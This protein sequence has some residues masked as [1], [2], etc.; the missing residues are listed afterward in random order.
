MIS[1]NF[2]NA[3]H[4]TIVIIKISYNGGGAIFKL[5]AYDN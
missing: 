2:D 1:L 3:I 4:Q 5:L